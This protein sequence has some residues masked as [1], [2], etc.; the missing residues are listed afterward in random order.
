MRCKF[1]R[2]DTFIKKRSWSSDEY[3][4]FYVT[5][6]DEE[7]NKYIGNEH[8]ISDRGVITHINADLIY[9]VNEGI[10]IPKHFYHKI[11]KL[12]DDAQLEA[13]AILLRVKHEVPKHLKERSCFVFIRTDGLWSVNQVE[14]FEAI[15]D[16]DEPG[17][18]LVEVLEEEGGEVHSQTYDIGCRTFY[19]GHSWILRDDVDE[20]ED[21]IISKLAYNK[22]ARIHSKLIVDLRELLEIKPTKMVLS[23]GKWGFYDPETCFE[24]PCQWADASPFSEGVAAVAND[25]GR[26]GY[27]DNYGKCAIPF[28]WAYAYPFSEGY[29]AVEDNGGFCF[30]IDRKGNEAFPARW[31]RVDFFSEG[32]AGVLNGDKWGFIDKT[33]KLVVPCMWYEVDWFHNG[34]AKVWDAQRNVFLIDPQ[35]HIVALGAEADSYDE[36]I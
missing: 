23:D 31:N 6:A 29:A 11:T 16:D 22:I 25:K 17:I 13:T 2:G 26:Y 34:K 32:L 14:F 28:R 12:I 15:N 30:F 8:M 9:D 36:G 19:L 1:K 10:P 24:I 7:T 3:S 4:V 18:Y 27:I 33:G 20:D 21:F 5:Y 35:G